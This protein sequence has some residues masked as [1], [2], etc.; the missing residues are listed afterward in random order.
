[1]AGSEAA[2]FCTLLGSCLRQELNPRDYL[3]WLFARLPAATNKN[4]TDLTP[5]AFAKL[6]AGATSTPRIPRPAA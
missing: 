2:T 5:A 4:V 3:I 6:K 1:M